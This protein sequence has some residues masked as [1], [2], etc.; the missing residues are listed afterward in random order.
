MTATP[1]DSAHLHKL[2][3]AGA[4][5]K[6]FSDSAEI[7]AMM[8]ALGTLAKVQ[9]RAGVI[10]ETAAKAIHRASLELQ[11]DPRGLAERAARD[12]SAV[13]A[14]VEAFAGLMQAPDF[15]QYLAQDVRPQDI[16]DS[17]L[18]L[19]LRQALAI[20]ETEIEA[21]L[22]ELVALAGSGRQ[23]CPALSCG[24]SLLPLRDA[25]PGLRAR[26]LCV[27]LAGDAGCGP[28]MPRRWGLPIPGAT[29]VK[30]AAGHAPLPIGRRS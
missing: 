12:G 24:R 26:A 18:M 3:A 25:L 5:G 14:L 8:I 29:P 10:P 22:E 21:L 16:E 19:R 6:L 23:P 9:G 13:P 30:S 11:V 20:C 27:S 1:F 7:R 15:A 17:A 4:L 2:F 28:P